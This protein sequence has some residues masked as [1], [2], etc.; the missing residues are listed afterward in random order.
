MR[1]R[2]QTSSNTYCIVHVHNV[3]G[4]DMIDYNRLYYIDYMHI[5]S[6]QRPSGKAPNNVGEEAGWG[7]LPCATSHLAHDQ[8]IQSAKSCCKHQII[9][10]HA[11]IHSICGPSNW[12]VPLASSESNTCASFER[13]RPCREL[14]D[15]RS[16][17]EV[18]RD[19]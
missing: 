6:T 9:C 16:S 12:L 3:F 7:F 4:S 19:Q 8:H 15:G 2:H 11:C 1:H 14:K 18:A 17:Q 5:D 13:R 10:K